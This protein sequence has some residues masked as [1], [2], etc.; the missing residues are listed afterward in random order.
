MLS[1]ETIPGLSLALQRWAKLANALGVIQK[2]L[3][4]QKH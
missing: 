2:A 4:I 1:F 3:T